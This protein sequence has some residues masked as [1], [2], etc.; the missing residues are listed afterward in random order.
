VIAA[1]LASAL[2]PSDS[3]PSPEAAPKRPILEPA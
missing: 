2:M 3:E 1:K